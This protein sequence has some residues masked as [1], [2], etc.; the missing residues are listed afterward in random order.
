M[1]TKR[2]TKTKN[3]SKNNIINV[4]SYNIQKEACQKKYKSGGI[5]CNDKGSKEIKII[6]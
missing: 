2:R 1:R 3:K 5:T 4:L 6:G